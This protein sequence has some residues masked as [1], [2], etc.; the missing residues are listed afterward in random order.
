MKNY[1]IK[2]T[3]LLLITLL[4]SCQKESTEYTEASPAENYKAS[5]IT[6]Q[7]AQNWLGNQ[8]DTNY[9]NKYPIGWQAAKIIQTETGNRI[10]IHLP[11]QP[12]FQHIKQGYRQL[13]IQKD[14]QTKKITATIIE[15]IPEAIYFQKK[16]KIDQADF[17]GRI[18]EYDLNYQFQK[19][20]IYS[21]GKQIGQSR[22]ATPA[23][24]Q[25]FTEKQ[26]HTQQ[27]PK[28]TSTYQ[29]P[30]DNSTQAMIVQNCQWIQ[31]YYID[32][33]GVFTVYTE[34]I[35][36]TT[37]YEDQGYNYNDQGTT[38]D[39]SQN[40]NNNQG[41][42]SNTATA[43]EPANLPGEEA[44]NVDPKK[45]TKCFANIPDQGA[46]FQVKLLVQEPLPGTS[47]NIGPN[48]FGHVAIQL[49]K[50]KGDQQITQVIGF[51]PTGTGLSKLISKSTMKDNSDLEYNLAASYFTTAENFQ[52]IINYIANP[53]T[54]YHFT[55][56]N[57]ATFAYYAAQAAGIAVP[58]P[59]TQIGFAGPGGAG[60][61]MTP[62]GMATALRA[63]KANN[64]NAD[65]TQAGGTAP[66]S[67][68]ECN[69][70]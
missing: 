65:I 6:I 30:Q 56:F 61:A 1:N 49:T 26:K 13:S 45:M 24:R 16:Q 2:F 14:P 33:E 40:Q 29:L 67:K 28:K 69:E 27:K 12:T 3:F 11:G 8:P 53:P 50:Q 22:P 18:L 62:S 15:I 46:A 7:E 70:E 57:C 42:G 41:G 36:T 37:T 20:K 66:A 25:Q 35:C 10:Q 34:R 47:F 48:S 55:D 52:K 60:T 63:Q 51:Y 32:A 5:Q 38:Y 54:N 59:T 21:G 31:S 23:E 4:T 44:D 43:P 64:P 9:L 17:T 19:G 68:G 39:P 58:N